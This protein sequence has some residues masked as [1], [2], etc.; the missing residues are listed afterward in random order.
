MLVGTLF[1]LVLVLATQ[2][3]SK[4][5]YSYARVRLSRNYIPQTP[6]TIRKY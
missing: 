4:I 1:H 6:S 5:R 3:L 2:A